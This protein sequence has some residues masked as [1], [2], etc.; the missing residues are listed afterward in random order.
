M[1][2]LAALLDVY[3]RDALALTC[4]TLFCAVVENSVG[5]MCEPVQYDAALIHK[6]TC[7]HRFTVKFPRF[8]LTKLSWSRYPE[9]SFVSDLSPLASLTTL[10][11]LDCG[12]ACGVTDLSPL[13]TLTRL[14]SLNGKVM[15]SLSDLMFMTAFT[16]LEKLEL[17]CSEKVWDLS[18]LSVR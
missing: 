9:Q 13:T 6:M 18:P 3:D 11:H 7:L 14:R 10:E 15:R 17:S 5:V 12:A 16:K 4:K 2:R 8:R 1:G